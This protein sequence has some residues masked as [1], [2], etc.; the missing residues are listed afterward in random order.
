MQTDIKTETEAASTHHSETLEREKAW[1]RADARR[2]DRAAGL[3]PQ[4]V[5][6]DVRRTNPAFAALADNERLFGKHTLGSTFPSLEGKPSSRR[7]KRET[8]FTS[9]FALLPDCRVYF[10]QIA[11]IVE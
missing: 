4:A 11:R 6:D 8:L 1:E 7:G 9:A 3:E 2:R 5:E 10:A